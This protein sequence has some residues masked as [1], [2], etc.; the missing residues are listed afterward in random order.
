M[1]GHKLADREEREDEYFLEEQEGIWGGSE[2][3]E[4]EM[5]HDPYYWY[6]YNGVSE[7]DFR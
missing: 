3:E 5:R 4:Q 7:R 2:D 6:R 1:Y